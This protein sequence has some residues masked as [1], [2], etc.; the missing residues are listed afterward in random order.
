MKTSRLVAVVSA[1]VVTLLP[2][3]KAEARDPVEKILRAVGYDGYWS[4]GYR[5]KDWNYP[6]GEITFDNRTREGVEVYHID[7]YGRWNWGGAIRAGRSMT[8]SSPVGDV[9]VVKDRWGEVVL[10]AE[11]TRRP[12]VVEVRI[13]GYFPRPEGKRGGRVQLLIVNELRGDLDL[14][15]IDR[16]GRWTWVARISGRGGEISLRSFTGQAW[17]AVNRRGE[18]V[19]TFKAGHEDDQI[20][21]RGGRD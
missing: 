5:P 13:S 8:V 10:R 14:Y 21:F 1:V 20:V 15:N 6:M 4:P 16:S 2:L 7:R 18:I 12:T 9:W 3:V 11:A 19:R 17:K